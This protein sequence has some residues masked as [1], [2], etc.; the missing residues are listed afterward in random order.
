MKKIIAGLLAGLSELNKVKKGI[1]SSPNATAV[2]IAASVP[3]DASSPLT[4]DS[5][6]E[7]DY[8][9]WAGRMRGKDMKK[10]VHK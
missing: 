7:E 6:S 10:G 4:N 9:Q 3:D 1:L 5:W 8:I 2:G